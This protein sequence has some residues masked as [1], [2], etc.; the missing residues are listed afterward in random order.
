MKNQVKNKTMT[1]KT[2]YFLAFLIL[3]NLPFGVLGQLSASAQTSENE[4]LKSANQNG[5]K[6]ARTYYDMDNTILKAEYYFIG[7]DSTNVDGEY[8]L[9]H[10][11]GELKS[12]ANFKEGEIQGR[13]IEYY[14]NGK[15]KLV[16]SY[17]EG[18]KDGIFK[19]YYYEGGLMAE[20]TCKDDKRNG[21]AKVYNEKQIIVQ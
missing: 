14:P 1:N 8:K 9:F 13:A 18:K 6:V 7:T 21:N 3:Y 20:Y 2:I 16:G 19:E 4:R 12:I 11:T 17:K 10:V 15:E 5:R